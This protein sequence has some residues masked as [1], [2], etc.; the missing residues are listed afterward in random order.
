MLCDV[1][2]SVFMCVMGE[3]ML[4][5]FIVT[6]ELRRPHRVL[7]SPGAGGLQGSKRDCDWGW[8]IGG[9][10]TELCIESKM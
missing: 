3:L 5:L 9:I 2:N 10:K 4:L 1:M 8:K 6:H 7:P